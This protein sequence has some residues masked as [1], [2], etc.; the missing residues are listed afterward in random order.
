MVNETSHFNN[1]DELGLDLRDFAR[2]VERM[3]R[4]CNALERSELRDALV[5]L[6]AFREAAIEV[7]RKMLARK[8][9]EEAAEL[10]QRENSVFETVD[11]E[12]VM[13]NAPYGFQTQQWGTVYTGDMYD[14][15]L[16]ENKIVA[17]KIGWPMRRALSQEEIAICNSLFV[18]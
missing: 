1:T 4:E 12:A 16:S 11:G 18:R 7:E 5:H 15:Q 9:L 17:A 13:F 3:E 10:A 6:A 8:A 14:L 2:E